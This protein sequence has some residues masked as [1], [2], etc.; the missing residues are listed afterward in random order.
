M[1]PILAVYI[2]FV[3]F[4]FLVLT[5]LDIIGYRK[6]GRSRKEEERYVAKGGRFNPS[7]LVIVPCRGLDLTL[8]QNLQSLKSQ[9][10]PRYRVV[11][12]VD[13]GKD[14]AVPVIRR[15]GVD[16]MIADANRGRCS[17]KV[18]AVLSAINAHRNYDVYVIAD[19]DVCVDSL[20]LKRIT[21]PLADKRIGLS[22]MYPYF[23]PVGGFWSKVKLLW[24]FVGE[25][26]MESDTT[27]F[28]WGGSLAFRKELLDKDALRFIRESEYSVSDDISI[29]K[30][31]QK[32]GLRIAYTSMSQPIVN[33]DEDHK[34]FIEWSN[35]QTALSILG[36][37]NNLYVGVAFYAAESIVLL[38]SVMLS[39]FVSP[40]FLV[41]LL[42]LAQAEVKTYR[43]TR[44]RHR[45]VLLLL[46]FMSFVYL[47]NLIA[48]SRIE[49]I[50][51]R[52]RSYPLQHS[53]G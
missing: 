21:E 42:H 35:R 16:C 9:E 18:N 37:R 6:R 47:A 10:Y 43:R 46:P 34:R 45:A 13:E 44:G 49:S 12:V 39:V 40:L 38:S 4:I 20:W 11:A 48:A 23:N 27:R 36:Y 32:K 22:T 17:G 19:S 26:L 8:Q 1:S 52:G 51:W 24:G 28:G 2:I 15:A 7:A 29:T 3:T 25:G 30:I 14:K 53:R 31:V 41:F 50:T 33:S 5:A